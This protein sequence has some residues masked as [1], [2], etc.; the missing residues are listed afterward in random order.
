MRRRG[1]MVHYIAFV[2][3]HCLGAK[4]PRIH[5]GFRHHQTM[6]GQ[7]VIKRAGV[8]AGKSLVGGN[9]TFNLCQL[10]RTTQHPL[11]IHYRRYL[12]FSQRVAFNGQGA[13]NGLDAVLLAQLR[14]A[15]KCTGIQP[16][17]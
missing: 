12:L 1:N 7:Q 2:N 11:A 5:Q 3:P 6:G 4:G 8:K 10:P 16:A 9:S 14:R 17:R 13:G 15:F